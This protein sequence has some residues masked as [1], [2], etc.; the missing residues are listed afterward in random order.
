MFC[1][2]ISHL[3]SGATGGG[4]A[5]VSWPGYAALSVSEDASNSTAIGTVTA[6]DGVAPLSYSIVGGNG[7][8]IFAINSSSGQITVDDNTN[9][10]YEDTTQYILTIRATDSDSPADTADTNITINVTNVIELP[11]NTVLPVISG[12]EQVGQALSTTNGSWTSDSLITYSY[13]WRRS[14]SDIS[15]ATSASYVLQTADFNHTITVRVSATNSDGSANATSAATGT[16]AESV[17]SNTAIPVISGTAQVGETLSVTDG[18]WSSI[19]TP[20]YSYQWQRAGSDISGATSS[21][22]T[23][24][25]ADYNN[26]ITC[27]VTATNTAGAA[28]AESAATGTV[29]ENV[30]INTALPVISGSPVVG[31]TLN[32]TTG[33]WDSISTPGY[34]YQWQA[35]GSNISGATSSSYALTSSELGAVITCE[36]TA[37]NTVGSDMAESSGT[38]AVT[39]GGSSLPSNSLYFNDSSTGYLKMSHSDFGSYN[40]Q[41]FAIAGSVRNQASGTQGIIMHRRS[42]ST[43]S[44]EVVITTGNAIQFRSKDVNSVTAQFVGTTT[45]FTT[46]N[47]CA[48]LIHFDSA[49]ATSTD[50]IKAWINNSAE[51]SS[52][53]TAPTGNAVTSTDDIGIGARPHNQNDL[54]GGY[55]YQLTFFDGALPDPADVFDG[56][57]GKL[58]DLSGLTGAKSLL[59]AQTTISDAILTTDWTNAGAVT[60]ST[61]IPT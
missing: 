47:Y 29:A 4:S 55:I 23:L 10:D 22:Y 50:R 48:F 24:V 32:V 39:A 26:T 46:G 19:S 31:Q 20:T 13:Q 28:M 57:G 15:G 60:T 14:G 38:S 33:T 44:F 18:T 34:S 27:E 58:K 42:L 54:L 37:T 59:D 51:S 1:F 40:H 53:Y 7:D 17:P 25:S 45:A 3:A 43:M 2:P 35:D 11:N 49:N 61:T 6:N 52:S 9:L 56:T 41:K 36:V 16:I 21:S 12:T 8:A 5:G 30:P